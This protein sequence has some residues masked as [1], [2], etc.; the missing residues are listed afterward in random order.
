MMWTFMIKLGSNMWAKKGSKRPYFTEAEFRYHEEVFCDR[1]IWKKV[2]DVLPSYGFNTVLIDVGE[3]IKLDS[4]PELAI[5]GCWEKEE[6]RAELNR[7]RKLG[8]TP[9]PKLNFS[10]AHN[11]WMQDYSYM[12]GSELYYKVCEEILLEVMELFDYPKFFHLGLDEEFLAAQKHNPVRT[13]RAPYKFVEDSNRLFQLCLEHGVRPAI[14][15]GGQSLPAW[16]GEEHLLDNIPKEVLI[17]CCF[18][19]FF[20]GTEP[21]ENGAPYFKRLEEKGYELWPCGSQWMAVQNMRQMM[22]WCKDNLRPETIKGYLMAPWLHTIPEFYHG[23][24]FGAQLFGY[25]KELS[26]P[27]ELPLVQHPELS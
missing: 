27:D 2:I 11:A 14:W 9:I 12:V 26:Y 6:F 15:L 7:I 3:A 17:A 16:G 25:A 1:R 21:E 20:Y 23:L 4:H 5:P 24:L 10:A 22:R 13:I 8:L 18:Y 19:G